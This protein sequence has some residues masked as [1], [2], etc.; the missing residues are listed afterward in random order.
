MSDLRKDL[1]RLQLEA[2]GENTNR[3]G[4]LETPSRVVKSWGELYSGYDKDPKDLLT[5]FQAGTYNQI[6]LLKDIEMFSMCEHHMLPFFGKAHVAYIPGEHVIGISKLARLVDMFA[7]RLQIQERI[8][9]Q[10][11]DALMDYLK[12]KAAACIIEAQHMCL[13]G[14]ALVQLAYLDRNKFPN[15]VPIRELVGEEDLFVYCYNTDTEKISIDSVKSVW[16]VGKREVFEVEY[17]WFTWNQHKQVRNTQSIKVT[18][19]HPFMLK[20]KSKNRYNNKNR[21]YSNGD[22]LTIKDGLSV[23]DSLM[24][25]ACYFSQGKYSILL[26]DGSVKE[27]HRMLLEHKI[28]RVLT[29]AEIAHHKNENPIDNTSDN[30]MLLS[31]KSEHNKIHK[32]FKPVFVGENHKVISIKK[33]GV[34]DVYDIE[35]ETFHNFAVNG[36]IIHNCMKMRGVSKQNSIMVTSSMRGAFLDDIKSRQELM[37]MIK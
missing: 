26:N 24:P 12:P 14:D 29:S 5:V 3:E 15:G 18:E 34:E 17:E 4:L 10:V 22:Y 2:I 36:I 19:D 33:I 21:K 8:G 1:I 35:T 27:E 9:E 16:C 25:F 31:S 20:W 13:S 28:G 11:T 32:K 23:G 7:R 6:V 30:L 37:N